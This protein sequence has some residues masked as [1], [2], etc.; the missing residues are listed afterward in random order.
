M[1]EWLLPRQLRAPTAVE[2]GGKLRGCEG[3]KESR[4]TEGEASLGSVYKFQDAKMT[5]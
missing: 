3:N 4:Q 5:I 2:D 1:L